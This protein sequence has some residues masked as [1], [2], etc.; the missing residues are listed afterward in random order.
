VV[1][2]KLHDD[3]GAAMAYAQSVIDYEALPPERRQKVKAERTFAVLKEAM[4]DK[5]VTE[6]QRN[7]LKVLRYT[8]PEPKDR[9]AASALIDQL[10]KGRAR[11]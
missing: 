9:A 8:G 10:L 5:T 11:A 7:Y 4:R 6:R 1:L 3:R 2:T